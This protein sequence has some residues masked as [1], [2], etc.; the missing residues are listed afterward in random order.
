MTSTKKATLVQVAGENLRP[1]YTKHGI[2][3]LL[4]QL[5]KIRQTGHNR[6]I[7]CCPSHNDKSPSLAIRDDDG[8]ILL[9]CFAGCSAYEIVSAVGM[10]ISDLFPE[11]REYSTQNISK[12]P[13]PAADVLRCIQVEALIVA[14][15]ASD[16]A[17]D[18]PLSDKQKNRLLIAA[19]RIG[20]AYV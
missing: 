3:H 8:K 9:N 15:A 14:M 20:G 17:K 12:N 1:N 2:D 5:L 11:Q 13:F 19:A 10:E 6:W 7:A 4:A 16:I 18:I